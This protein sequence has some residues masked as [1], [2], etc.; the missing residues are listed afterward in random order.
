MKYLTS[1]FLSLII[2]CNLFSQDISGLWVGSLYNDS[3]Q[4]NYYYQLAISQNNGKYVGYSYTTFVV[5]GKTAVGVKSLKI[6]P[7]KVG[8]VLEDD[9]L[10]FNNYP[11][12]PPRGV[13]QITSLTLSE[14]DE[15]KILSGMF[16]TSRTKQY[17]RQVT[18]K[19]ILGEKKELVND[20]LLI[21]LEK[22][23]L[24]KNLLFYK[25][26]PSLPI[27]PLISK[28][29]DYKNS[30]IDI[31]IVNPPKDPLVEIEKRKIETIQTVYFSSDS[32][33]L[34][35]YDNGYVD[36]DSVSLIVNGK[37]ELEHQSLSTKAVSKTIA[38][39]GDSLKIIMYAENLGSIAPNTGL[40]IIY[41]GI[42]RHE[43]RFEG[44]LENNAAILLKR[45]R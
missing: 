34:Q 26:T 33:T 25:F 16:I 24:S 9:E 6:I 36:G 35:L 2:Y 3:T 41:D 22:L 38:A 32:I 30:K 28:D 8:F 20:K 15:V 19:V 42:L 27:P 14:T 11:V 45:R 5:D 1:I 18:G 39:I 4:Q 12:A 10:L 44:D 43:I 23:G 31:K 7:Q 17:G 21:Q 40:L 29:V 37:L 13:K